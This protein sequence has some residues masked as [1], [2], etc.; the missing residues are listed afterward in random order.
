MRN[1][2]TDLPPRSQAFFDA[3][4]DDWGMLYLG[5]QHLLDFFELTTKTRQLEGEIA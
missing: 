5:G 1:S 4:P 3:L 2:A